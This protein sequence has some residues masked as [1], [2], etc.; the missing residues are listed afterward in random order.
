MTHH[1]T[2]CDPVEVKI[3]ERYLQEL[4]LDQNFVVSKHKDHDGANL[5]INLIPQLD[6]NYEIIKFSIVVKIK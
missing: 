5:P 6:I 3:L 4:K 1:D 2:I